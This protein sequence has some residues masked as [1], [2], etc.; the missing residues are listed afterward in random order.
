MSVCGSALR[1]HDL[2]CHLSG[3]L[4]YFLPSN[5]A[6]LYLK[7]DRLEQ[8]EGMSWS[9]RIPSWDIFLTPL[10]RGS[11]DT[12]CMCYLRHFTEILSFQCRLLSTYYV[13]KVTVV[14]RGRARG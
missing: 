1:L 9:S 6:P 11:S 7:E 3:H 4:C 14:F 8:R 13:H 2:C 10:F 12:C 5:R